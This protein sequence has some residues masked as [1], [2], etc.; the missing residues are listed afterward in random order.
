MSVPALGLYGSGGAYEDGAGS[1]E[2]SSG[3]AWS[4]AA[5]P[6]APAI[7]TG[8]PDGRA[9]PAAPPGQ[10]LAS[11]FAEAA[12]A[13]DDGEY[14]ADAVEALVAELA[15][16]EFAE[17]L[18][19]LADEAAARHL[20]S[21]G[22]W[23][24]DAEAPAL[25]VA[26]STGWMEQ[27]A[28]EADRILG[29]LEAYFA[30][31]PADSLRDGEIEAASGLYGHE[32]AGFLDPA[33]AQQLLFGKL[34]D[35]VKKAAQGVGK[36]A[37]KGL[38]AVG[39]LLPLGKLFGIL[40]RLVRPLLDNVLR[41]AIGR[42][43]AP[44]RPLAGRLAAQLRGAGKPPVE[45][46]EQ[47]SGPEAE[48]AEAFDRTL[49]EMVLA[50]NEAAVERLLAE[51]E[52]PAGNGYQAAGSPG[53]DLDAARARLTRELAEA[54][55][56]EPPTAQL[57]QFIPAVMAAMPLI[58][59]GV[60]V[61]GRERVVS[62]IAKPLAQLIQG[63]VGA[64][65]AALLSRHIA[66]AGLG[67]L[68]LEADSDTPALGPEALAGATEDTVRQVMSLPAESLD[69]ELLLAT[70]VQEAF[71][72]AAAQHLPAAVLRPELTE[73]E[74]EAEQGVWVMMPRATRPCFRYRKY[75]RII[76][77]RVTRPVA[78]AVVLSG[79]DTLER[80]LLDAGAESWPVDGEVE[81]YELLPGGA[82]G[83]L[84]DF[85]SAGGAGSPAVAAGEFEQL[86]GTAATLLAGN[87][88]LAQAGRHGQPVW[89]RH[90]GSRYF[91]FR[92]RGRPL[93]RRHVFG[94][95]FD[96]TAP[97]PV[98]HVHLQVGEREA[99]LLAEHVRRR[100]LV[101]VVSVVRGL[102][103]RPALQA[104]AHRLERMLARHGVTVATGTGQWLAE[105]LADAMLRAVT[106]QLPAAAPALAQAARDP[107][108][109]ATLTFTFAF[110]DRAA[111]AAGTPTGDPTVTIRPGLHRA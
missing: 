71:G 24:S 104:M 3:P 92:F 89:H 105:Q 73:R 18:A 66:S 81:L 1:A 9:E 29:A 103:D 97:Q 72:E 64:Q 82:L 62:G 87:P 102:L 90:A 110:A 15:D 54:E 4:T 107:A 45:P 84:A 79:G 65:A 11:P 74:R 75:S 77:V 31:R 12:M 91:R 19:A 93:R 48:L 98:L 95:R 21:V 86:S 61:A 108:P 49:A 63:M 30:D 13:A 46:V 7:L 99:H 111:M 56:G 10:V 43:P 8:A 36:L 85:E 2:S 52:S 60:R 50:P 59:M 70:E 68:G 41:R 106:Q 28:G 69:N 35:K 5:S 67:L 88:R 26:D 25:A 34:L 55:P 80:R 101:Q 94:L 78:R 40:R 44:L 20:R 38:Q 42:L 47:E 16:D 96:L 37:K 100:Q 58:K 39:R 33:D 53:H 6:F 51:A 17:A 57:E 32:N 109:G 83:Q 23:S 22:T 76:P 27:V 14:A